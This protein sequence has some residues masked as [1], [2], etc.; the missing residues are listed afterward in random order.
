[1]LDVMHKRSGGKG[2]V[3]SDPPTVTGE[4]GL[5]MMIKRRVETL[6]QTRTAPS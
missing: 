4:Y 6:E 2:R 1:L 5:A 3:F